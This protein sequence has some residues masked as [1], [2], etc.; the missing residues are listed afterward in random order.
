MT[1]LIVNPAFIDKMLECLD[2][3]TLRE[4]C[5]EQGIPHSKS[6]NNSRYNM[7]R[8]LSQKIDPTKGVTIEIN[9]DKE[10]ET[11]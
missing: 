1:K 4:L 10:E 2:R 5:N 8:L 9:F 6:Y 7:A 3:E 11:E